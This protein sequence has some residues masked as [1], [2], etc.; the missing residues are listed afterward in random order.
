MYEYMYSRRVHERTKGSGRYNQPVSKKSRS[1]HP[2]R[3]SDTSV[4][5]SV[6]TDLFDGWVCILPTTGMRLL[7]PINHFTSMQSDHRPQDLRNGKHD[8][9]QTATQ[10][11]PCFTWNNMK[12]DIAHTGYL[13]TCMLT[14]TLVR[15]QSLP[16]R[17]RAK[18]N[19]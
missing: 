9:L 19:V 1:C 16:S 13:I 3:P 10:T 11:M 5:N 7:C 12:K 18:L 2:I 4:W 15:R 6:R 14:P 17:D 8:T